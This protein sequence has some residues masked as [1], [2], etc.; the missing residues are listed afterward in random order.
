MN[1]LFG[2]IGAAL[3]WMLADPWGWGWDVTLV[4]LGG[5]I[6][7][8]LSRTAK[9]ATRVEL[10]E[11]SLKS[12][13]V[14]AQAQA[15]PP[16]ATVTATP[17][18]RL[19]AP[20]TRAAEGA[21]ATSITTPTA[22]PVAEAARVEAVGV[23]VAP[24]VPEAPKPP[25]QPPLLARG[26]DAV[27]NWFSVGNV[28]VKVGMLVLFA[29]VAALLKYATDAGWF[30]LPIEFRMAGIALAAIAA[31]LFGWHQRDQR[32][33]FALS[34]QGGA[35]GILVLTVF[36]AFRLYGLLPAGAAFALLVLIVAATCVLAV[37]QNSLALAVLGILAGYLAP[38]LIS[39]GS[40]NHVALF[41]YYAVLNLAVF[42]VAW[43]R[44]W[45]VLNL[46]G[47]V[48][49]YAVATLWGVLS[50]QPEKFASTEPFL[51]LF[52]VIYLLVPLLF[53]RKR[54]PSRR[55]IV[56][57]SL[58]FGNPLIAFAL[59]AGLLKG[60]PMGL[61]LSALVL[62]V[63]YAALA[64]WLLRRTTLRVIGEAHAIL[65]IG[66]ATLAVPLALS[67]GATACTFALEGAGL[68]WLGLRQ[69]R[70]FPRWSGYALQ[71]LAGVAWVFGRSPIDGLPILNGIAI[72]A[73]LISLAGFASAELLR[74]ASGRAVLVWLLDGWALLWWLIA[75]LHEI[76]RWVPALSQADATLGLTAVSIAIAGFLYTRWQRPL[77][78]WIAAAGFVL[79]IVIAMQ[80]TQ[81]H[82]QPFAEWG[83]LGWFAF[84][85][86]G[87]LALRWIASSVAIVVAH[88]GWLWAWTLTL[89]L[90][91]QWFATDH[92]L[93][94]GWAWALSALPL[95]ALATLLRKKP[96][97]IAWPI[98]DAFSHVLP[99]LSGLLLLALVLV[100]GNSLFAPGSSAPLPFVPVINPLELM[101]LAILL[102][103]ARGDGFATFGNA[104]VSQRTRVLVVLGFALITF[105]TLRGVHHV[106][107]VPWNEA[108]VWT[109]LAQTSLTVVWSLVGMAAWIVGSRR[110]NRSLWLAGAVLMGIVLLKLLLVDRNHLGNLYGIASFI[111][112]GLLCTVI[113]YLA[114]APAKTATENA[115]P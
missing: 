31:L 106:G 7:W 18:F 32:P 30:T 73:L 78:A 102:L 76:D 57:G 74:R 46:I 113:G 92:G 66:F 98:G 36:A 26:F 5:V 65:A 86:G 100:F 101:Q 6:G 20:P 115:S 77:H 64:W 95:L 110:G 9:L 41:S 24:P 44:P 103:I 87:A 99:G 2:L 16:G 80:Q 37:R 34:L 52:F 12:L 15:Q 45:R 67:A 62:A 55:D 91:L 10:L 61:A 63:L 50:Y 104:V 11:R 97:W 51:I 60:D 14:G 108:L 39:T 93:A 83:A 58:L 1:F 68:V 84:A 13:T 112:Y 27:R 114:P 72:G 96:S 94:D 17:E 3:T 59:Q 111:A 82:R 89:G 38:I 81:D 54:E 56:D 25:A 90:L 49:T 88:N 47:F 8:L 79:A 75:W 28:P 42:A 40:G 33:A 53:A 4:V 109:T 21:A 85:I 23:P 69:Q 48:F 71:L 35:V 22:P 105:A 107:G 29:G 19:E 43:V 70:R